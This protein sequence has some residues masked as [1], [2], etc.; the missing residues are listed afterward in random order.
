M[1]PNLN[2]VK[3]TVRTKGE[4]HEVVSEERSRSLTL[5]PN[6]MMRA[7]GR[8]QCPDVRERALLP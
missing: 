6:K 2:R 8:Q 4:K 1:L 5:L 7:A 3:F